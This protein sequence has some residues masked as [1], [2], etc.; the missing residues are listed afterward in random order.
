MKRLICLLLVAIV[1]C[2]CLPTPEQEY[3]V[4][5]G[6]DT[7]EQKLDATI[8]PD[9]QNSANLL[10]PERWEEAESE[11]YKGVY[12]GVDAE[13]IQ[14]TDDNLAEQR[15]N[16]APL[17]EETV[18]AA[19]AK[20]QIFP[21]R[22]DEN[23]IR[24]F[25]YSHPKEIVGKANANVELLPFSKIQRIV[26]NTLSVCCPVERYQGSADWQWT[27]EVYRMV[28]TAYTLHVKDSDEYYEMPCWAVLFDGWPGNERDTQNMRMQS[29]I[30]NAV[31]G[32][33][34][35]NNAGY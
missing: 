13:I 18:A 20:I 4:N 11:V 27:L 19:Q 8:D 30:I 22:W 6:D 7:I 35:H 31:D 21:D 33:V 3:V 24:S 9:G 14:K 25:A 1:F 15:I 5:K 12:I 28:L 17:T 32:T 34:V 29:V 26:K 2:A 16:G 23:G 10:F